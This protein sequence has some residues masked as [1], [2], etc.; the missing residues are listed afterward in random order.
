MWTNPEHLFY[1]KQFALFSAHI[2]HSLYSARAVRGRELNGTM[3]ATV[4]GC[5][6]VFWPATFAKSPSQK[7]F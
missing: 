4:T 1:T 3:L 5:V 7:G 2:R 6:N